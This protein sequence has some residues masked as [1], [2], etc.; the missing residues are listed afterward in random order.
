MSA[1]FGFVVFSRFRVV[2]S[3]R[4][5]FHFTRILV[6]GSGKRNVIIN[7]CMVLGL[8][9]IM[10]GWVVHGSKYYAKNRI[11]VVKTEG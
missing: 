6:T 4:R 3:N 10:L 9:F 7:W 5:I 8:L 2:D 1:G 11:I